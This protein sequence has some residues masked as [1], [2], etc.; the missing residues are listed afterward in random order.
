MECKV[1][2]HPVEL[3]YWIHN[4]KVL[5]PSDRIKIS[6]DSLRIHIRNSQKDDQGIYQCFASNSR[7]QAYGISEYIIDGKFMLDVSNS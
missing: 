3:V 2:G 7:D 4:G 6:E 5:K 1:T